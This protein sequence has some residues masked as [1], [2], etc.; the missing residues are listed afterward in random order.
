MKKF[1]YYLALWCIGVALGVV[2]IDFTLWQ[3]GLVNPFAGFFLQIAA[4]W[5]IL[6]AAIALYNMART[7]AI[8]LLGLSLVPILA[9]GGLVTLMGHTMQM[10]PPA[11]LM[12]GLTF[13][14]LVGF[15]CGWASVMDFLAKPK[16]VQNAQKG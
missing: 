14:L 3:A 12:G 7:W 4:A 8:N 9:A 16:P 11:Q 1:D 2:T 10:S 15:V 13:I 5:C 6:G